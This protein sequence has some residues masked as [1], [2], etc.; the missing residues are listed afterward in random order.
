MISL[1]FGMAD[2]QD[3]L[4]ERSK[5]VDSSSTSASCMGSNP[6]AVRKSRGEQKAEGSK[7]T[8]GTL[9]NLG[10]QHSPALRQG[11]GGRSPPSQRMRE[12]GPQA[13]PKAKGAIAQ[14]RGGI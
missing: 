9:A 3:S 5:G 8:R 6:I 11:F 7:K 13:A 12:T 10:K 4:P 14:G 1:P 2:V